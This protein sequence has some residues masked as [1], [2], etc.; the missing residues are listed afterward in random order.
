[1]DYSGKVLSRNSRDDLHEQAFAMTA[2]GNLYRG[3]NL[4][5]LPVYLFNASAQRWQ[6]MIRPMGATAL[7]GA[8]GANLVFRVPGDADRMRL[9]WYAQPG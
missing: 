9:S 3:D 6:Q 5:G 2:D 8:D 4:R 7:V 1:M